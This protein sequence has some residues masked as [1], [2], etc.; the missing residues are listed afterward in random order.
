[1]ICP[2]VDF[3]I[4]KPD[5]PRIHVVVTVSGRDSDD[6]ETGITSIPTHYPDIETIVRH[7][8]IPDEQLFSG[9]YSLFL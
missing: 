8:W 6:Y 2:F 3:E 9:S 5:F 7:V 1:M 4:K